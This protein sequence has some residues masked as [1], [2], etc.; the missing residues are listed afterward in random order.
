MKKLIAL[1]VALML[2]L[3]AVAFAAVP[4]IDSSALFKITS[5]SPEADGFFIEIIPVEKMN[6]EQKAAFDIELENIRNAAS[7]KEYFAEAVDAEGNPVELADDAVVHELAAVIAG[8][9]DAELGDVT[10]NIEVPEVIEKGEKVAVMIGVV[11][12]NI[13]DTQDVAWTGFE[14][15][16]IDNTEEASTIQTVLNPATV[17]AI[18]NGLA[19]IAVAGK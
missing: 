3:S 4:S 14:G 16:A 5:I 17:E 13:D 2:C 8:G 11:T 9:Y 7:A 19:L 10:V 12:K 18:Q 6:D 15:E 1:T